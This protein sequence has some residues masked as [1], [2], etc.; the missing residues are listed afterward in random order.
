MASLAD[1]LTLKPPVMN[2]EKKLSVQE[3]AGRVLGEHTSSMMDMLAVAG[4]Y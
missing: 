4:T 2:E 1:S 3:R